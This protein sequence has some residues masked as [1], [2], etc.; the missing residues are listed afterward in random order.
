MG[1]I[2]AALAQRCAGGWGMEVVYCSRESKDAIAP[3]GSKHVDFD[4][5][6]RVSDFISVHAPLTQ[7]TKGKFNAYAFSKMKP[8]AVF[9]NTGRGEIHNQADLAQ[10]LEKKHI[11]SAGLDV[12][13][14]EPIPQ[15]DPLLRLPNCL[16]LPHIGSATVASRSAMAEIAA[17]NLLLGLQ[18]KALR[19]AVKA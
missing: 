10:A 18:G 4:T 1:R 11:F 9:V 2:G 17:D 3:K 16:V 12:T 8:T 7:E 6:L 5:L 13:S 14:P 15:T 19:C